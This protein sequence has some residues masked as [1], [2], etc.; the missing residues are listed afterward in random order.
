MPKSTSSPRELVGEQPAA[1]RGPKPRFSA[2]QVVDV[3]LEITRAEGL[4]AVTLKRVA[5]ELGITSMGLYRYF[6]SKEQLLIAMAARM[7]D[8]S[9]TVDLAAPWPD[10]I[11]SVMRDI[12][13]GLL[14]HPG[15]GHLFATTV[16]DGVAVDRAKEGLFGILYRAGFSAQESIDTLWVLFDYIVGAV[17][18]DDSVARQTAKAEISR[19]ARLDAEEFPTLAELAPGYESRGSRQ[20]FEYGLDL[21]ITALETKLADRRPRRSNSDRPPARSRRD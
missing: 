10:Q 14:S 1:R 11:R 6:D 12:Y 7:V 21:I 15:I 9:P 8:P 20:I 5:D 3:A 4:D 2:D 13:D 16:L 17:I 19:L 18:A